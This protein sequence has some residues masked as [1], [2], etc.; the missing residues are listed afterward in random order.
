MKKELFKMIGY[1]KDELSDCT[2]IFISDWVILL[3]RK[4]TFNEEDEEQIDYLFPDDKNDEID[5]TY[6]GVCRALKDYIV[7]HKSYMNYRQGAIE[8][9]F[10][11]DHKTIFG[12][13]FEEY[14]DKLFIKGEE[15]YLLY[16]SEG[17]EKEIFLKKDMHFVGEK[18]S[19]LRFVSPNNVKPFNALYDLKTFSWLI[20]PTDGCTDINFKSH[21][22]KVFYNDG[23]EKYFDYNRNEL[24][25]SKEWHPG[26]D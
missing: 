7:L 17:E 8:V 2:I 11:K 13:E 14:G 3:S 18:D 9:I 16:T 23:Q 10:R 26:K 15:N 24:P 19:F 4:R 6:S 1:Y 5:F 25:K 21:Y 22:F 20:C 12:L